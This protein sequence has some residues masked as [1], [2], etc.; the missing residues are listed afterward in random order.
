MD[1]ARNN[2][3]FAEHFSDFRTGHMTFTRRFIL[4]DLHSMDPSE[5]VKQME[6]PYHSIENVFIGKSVNPH[7]TFLLSEAPRF[8]EKTPNDASSLSL[9][10]AMLSFLRTRGKQSQVNRRR[11]TVLSGSHQMVVSNCLCYRFQIP[12]SDLQAIQALKRLPTMPRIIQ[13]DIL[14]TSQP[15]VA[16]QMT[17]LNTLLAATVDKTLS[18][19]VKFQVQKL[20][21]NGYLPPYKALELVQLTQQ[22][23]PELDQ[24]TLAAAV[25]RLTFQIPFPGPGTEASELLP[26]TLCQLVAENYEMVVREK[27]YS[28]DVTE[29]YE[30]L[31]SIH[32]ATVTPAGIYLNGPEPEMKN[33]I[34]R[35]YAAFSSYFLQVTFSDE[36]GEAMRYDRTASLH[37]I[38]HHRFKKVLESNITIA[39]RPYEVCL[40]STTQELQ[41]TDVL[42]N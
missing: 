29:Q 9:N 25:R 36:D 39:G 2:L 33:R 1:Y 32:K 23:L 27:T 21:M 3:A 11:I 17:Q 7:V 4:I 12:S 15:S 26:K 35:K 41:I 19:E 38:F 18:F 31:V 13:W 8:F 34:L 16:L 22:T 20:V 28:V 24:P 10:L 42:N 30:Q 37:D 5:P 14:Q 6:F 40:E